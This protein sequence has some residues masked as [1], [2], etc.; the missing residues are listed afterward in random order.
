MI[1]III[2]SAAAAAAAITA[3]AA[4]TVATAAAAAAAVVQKQK[5]SSIPH[6]AAVD[7]VLM[8]GSRNLI[9]GAS[10]DLPPPGEL[11]YFT[12]AYMSEYFTNLMKIFNT[13]V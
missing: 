7:P 6:G 4:T 2:I 1:F 10:N 8:Q 12:I 13:T 3:T 5:M 11:F 9:G